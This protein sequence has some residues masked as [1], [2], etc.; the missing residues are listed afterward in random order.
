MFDSLA[1]DYDQA[2]VPYFGRFGAELVNR[3][4]L[5]P[6]Y[7]VLDV[8]AG[9]GAVLLPATDDVG[10]TGHLTGIDLSEEMVRALRRD[11]AARGLVNV[12]VRVGD[13]EE[14]GVEPGSMDAVLA[15]LVL[16][17][18]P[19]PPR[20]VAAAH[21]ALRPG[22]VIAFTTFG[23]LSQRWA[24]VYDVLMPLAPK[25]GQPRPGH[26]S[27]LWDDP[28]AITGLLA[29]SGFVDVTVED[30]SYDI[31]FD[32][33]EHWFDWTWTVGIRALWLSMDDATREQ[34]RQA[35]I[36]VVGS[37]ARDDGTV[38]MPEQLRFTLGRRGE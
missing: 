14:P 34:A 29:D 15:G 18:V 16:F 3:S 19:D 10:P 20:A 25:A 31:T 2:G 8:G 33:P 7:R 5:Q 22:G 37:F 26:G 28:N 9:R 4:R 6:G 17:F 1:A 12:T 11:V 36:D 13:A 38:T 27:P 21:A 24:E 23:P 35:A 32:S 30:A